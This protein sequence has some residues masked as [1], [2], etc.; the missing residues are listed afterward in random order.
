MKLLTSL[1]ITALIYG[2][3]WFAVIQQPAIAMKNDSLV[4]PS[5]N[6]DG[7]PK[8]LTPYI[9]PIVS[10]NVPFDNVLALWT[11]FEEQLTDLDQ[12]TMTTDSVVLLY[13]NINSD[14]T[15]AHITIGFIVMQH[16]PEPKDIELPS[17]QEYQQLLSR[18]PYSDSDMEGAWEEIDYRRPIDA[19]VETHYLNPLGQEELSQL[20]V[21]YKQ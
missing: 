16:A 3:M 10:R 20:V 13:R 9:R 17:T 5:M 14:F 2:A 21:Y 15:R 12:I 7:S 11:E 8:Q 19:V 1:F 6:A 18:G 4:E